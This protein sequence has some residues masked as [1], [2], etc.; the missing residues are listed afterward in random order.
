MTMRMIR[1]ALAFLALA[2]PMTS[3]ALSVDAY[4]H[5]GPF[6]WGS[7]EVRA[8]IKGVASGFWPYTMATGFTISCP[9]SNGQ[10]I[11]DV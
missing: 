1:M 8:A 10:V 9:F 2:L 6:Q 3:G 11:E 4:L 5:I 7:T